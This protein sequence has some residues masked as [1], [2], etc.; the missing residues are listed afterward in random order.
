MSS[1]PET[2]KKPAYMI[3]KYGSELDPFYK[4]K[5]AD[6]KNNKYSNGG[7]SLELVTS[8]YL[9]RLNPK[10]SLSTWQLLDYLIV[11]ATPQT[12]NFNNLKQAS[13]IKKDASAILD[14]EEYA[15]ITGRDITTKS[16]KDKFRREILADLVLIRSMCLS[17]DYNRKPTFKSNYQT[18]EA[19]HF[20][21]RMLEPVR[22]PANGKIYIPYNSDFMKYLA[23]CP[24]YPFPAELFQL[25][26]RKAA[27]YMIGRHITF[28]YFNKRLPYQDRLTVLNLLKYTDIMPYDHVVKMGYGWGLRI[29][30]PF[31]NALE[32]LKGMAFI[33][34]CQLVDGS[35]NDLRI[36]EAEELKT[37]L[38][39]DFRTL[40]LLYKLF[41]NE[42]KK[43][44]PEKVE[45]T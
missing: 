45:P 4:L 19:A 39:A 17:F 5:S 12:K 32:D 21:G 30:K 13:Q 42:E 25:G 34:S 16:R 36:V 41:Q 23:V 24:V 9:K 27:A 7:Y 26:R 10:I 40:K 8:D 15:A 18:Q 28:Q 2:Q 6:L 11:L 14:L 44:E 31:L 43:A 38:Y 1:T 20:H 22:P 35:G 33:E 29:K 3:F 37:L